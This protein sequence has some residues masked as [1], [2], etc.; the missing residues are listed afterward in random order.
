[1][2]AATRDFIR[3]TAAKD[4]LTKK[5]NNSYW[6]FKKNH[7]EW[8]NASETPFQTIARDIANEDELI[9]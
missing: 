7:D 9:V 5:V 4:P 2:Y 8:Q 1:L 6:K 3:D